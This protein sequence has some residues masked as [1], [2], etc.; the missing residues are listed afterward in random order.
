M[1]NKVEML[2]TG[3][4]GRL[5]SEVVR[6]L[7]A[8]GQ[9]VISGTRTP[10]KAAEL[11]D[12]GSTV[13]RLDLN[14][15]PEEIEKAIDGAS[16]VL[17][18]ST[19]DLG[20]PGRRQRQHLALVR[21]A[22]AKGLMHI[23]YTSMPRPDHES[24]VPFAR[25]HRVTEEAIRSSGLSWSFLR[26]SWYFENLLGVL[27]AVL[28]TGRWFSAAGPGRL[29]FVSRQDAA[30]CAAAT[31]TGHTR[32]G[33]FEIQGPHAFNVDELAEVVSR[34]FSVPIAVS[35]VEIR[36][37]SGHLLAQGIEPDYVPMLEI[38][39]INQ[40]LRR[41]EGLVSDVEGLTGNLA[42]TFEDFL[43]DHHDI[44]Q[45]FADGAPEASLGR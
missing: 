44:I 19:D 8:S 37:L 38:T 43:R 24:P 7:I 2:V 18:V 15:T 11:K 36:D 28:R 33:V 16:R 29:A 42:M 26:N 30:R 6:R 10:L 4:S 27:P 40:K 45:R 35:H 21:A 39:D 20:V 23:S 1:A 17:L 32:P 9:A 3:A 14:D 13:R 5:G 34:E 22:T 41:F 25:D 12:L 31:L